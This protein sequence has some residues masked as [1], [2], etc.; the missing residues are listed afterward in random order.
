MSRDLGGAK[1]VAP[2]LAVPCDLSNVEAICHLENVE[3]AGVNVSLETL[4]PA[5]S[6]GKSFIHGRFVVAEI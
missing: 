5:V 1:C 3:P 6:S 2:S 4:C